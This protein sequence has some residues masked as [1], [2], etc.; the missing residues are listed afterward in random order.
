MVQC[1]SDVARLIN[2]RGF[3]PFFAGEISGFS[4]EE[5]VPPALW[6]PEEDLSDMGVWD[7][8]SDI[9]LEADCAYG[10]LYRKKACFVSMDVFPDLLNVRREAY[11]LNATEL[12]LLSLLEERHTLLS[13][14][15]KRLGGYVKPRTRKTANPLD[16]MLAMEEKKV[17]R[18]KKS[19]KESFET[20]VT[21]LQMSGKVVCA[22]FEYHCDREGKRYGWGMARYVTAADFFGS[23]RLVVGRSPEESFD[24]L[25][26]FLRERFPWAAEE[27]LRRVI[28]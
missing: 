13:R 14:E 3:L 25:L 17:K 9:I 28:L 23:E 10:K 16:A 18:P 19:A 22:A 12:H 11:P 4:L 15:W 24:R 1:V 8:K 7:W 20:A 26:T 2:E 6:F 5:E 27:Q 21:R